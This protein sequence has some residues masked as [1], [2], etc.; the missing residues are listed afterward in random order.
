[1]KRTFRLPG[2]WP[3]L[4]AVLLLVLAAAAPQAGGAARPHGEVVGGSPV[5]AG[6]M[7]FMAAIWYLPL[8]SDIPWCA[9]T[10][11]APDKVLTAA[12]CFYYLQGT[13]TGTLVLEEMEAGGLEVGVQGAGNA[14]YTGLKRIAVKSIAVYPEFDIDS[15]SA[16]EV[17]LIV[18]CAGDA[19]VMELAAPVRGAAPVTLINAREDGYWRQGRS[20]TAAGWSGDF[21]AQ[22]PTGPLTMASLPVFDQRLCER[23]F[24][25]L[26][27]RFDVSPKIRFDRSG[28]FC[29]YR[30]AVGPCFEEWG[31]P[32]LARDGKRWLQVGILTSV[33]S[34][35]EA[36]WANIYTGLADS[37]LNWWVRSAAGLPS[38][39]A[40]KGGR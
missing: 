18:A 35:T 36:K 25:G 5:K 24:E 30:T 31:G 34:C 21:V 4:L 39:R 7:P 3:G 12:S 14:P 17:A 6:E 10:L 20:L 1:M 37:D 15:C 23:R 28:S 26:N 19:A 13:P 27:G 8:E 22:P 16:P 2:A 11:I 9:G 40:P 32:A 33:F 38:P 29:L